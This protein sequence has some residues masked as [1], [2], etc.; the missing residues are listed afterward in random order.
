M[1]NRE[2]KLKMFRK[3][4][5]LLFLV[6]AMLQGCLFSEKE[7]EEL[8]E[9]RGIAMEAINNGNVKKITNFAMQYGYYDF[10]NGAVED[11]NANISEVLWKNQLWKSCDT[12]IFPE[13]L[14]MSFPYKFPY[15]EYLS[16]LSKY[17]ENKTYEKTTSYNI[18]LVND[19]DSLREY[20]VAYTTEKGRQEKNTES[21][22]RINNKWFFFSRSSYG[23]SEKRNRDEKALMELSQKKVS[24]D[25]MGDT[26][27]I[28]VQDNYRI[29]FL[30]SKNPEILSVQIFSYELI[31]I[32]KRSLVPED[33]KI[34]IR[35]LPETPA[36]SVY[37]I[38]NLLRWNGYNHYSMESA[39]SDISVFFKIVCL[40]IMKN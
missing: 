15:K 40:N 27:Q 6:F 23:F 26:I 2:Q 9:L 39:K 37:H 30:G 32:L 22:I 8:I 13:E 10:M 18:T 20:E 1:S 12:E 25:F 38:K 28:Y 21:F 16:H 29:R 34:I 7:P 11:F 36:N 35:A 24:Q 3:K 33:T 17:F 14:Y 19:Y 31:G 4:T 5:C